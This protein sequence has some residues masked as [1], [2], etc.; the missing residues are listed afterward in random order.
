MRQF[1]K[2]LVRN[3][4][5]DLERDI[6]KMTPFQVTALFLTLNAAEAVP[7]ANN[8][9]PVR[10]KFT[11]YYQ[12]GSVGPNNMLKVFSRAQGNRITP[13]RVDQ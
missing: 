7:L 13:S 1:R 10:P 12:A 2:L 3:R 9:F 5:V 4:K 6:T 8:R 11:S